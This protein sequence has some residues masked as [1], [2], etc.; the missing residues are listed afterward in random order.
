MPTTELATIPLKAGSNIGEPSDPA[1]ATF[2]DVAGSIA[3]QDGFENMQFGMGFEN[4]NTLQLAIDWSNKQKHEEF[5]KSDSYGPFVERFKTIIDGAFGLVH[6][7]FAPEGGAKRAMSA[8]ITEVATFYFD[9]EPPSDA[10]ES[11]KK[12]IE[13]SE[14]EATQKVYGWAYGTTHEEVEREGVKGKGTV[15]LIGWESQQDH[16]DF[17]ETDVFKQNIQ[18]LRQTAKSIEVHHTMFMNFVA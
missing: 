2:K 15:L 18:L 8:P 16:M 9:G 11:C 3:S 12:F 6:V 17:R 7:D 14:K 13:V 10:Y 5:M 1:A 4:A